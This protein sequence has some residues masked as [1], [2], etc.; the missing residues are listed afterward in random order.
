MTGLPTTSK[1][2]D[3]PRDQA[4]GEDDIVEMLESVEEGDD[5]VIYSDVTGTEAPTPAGYIDD[6]PGVREIRGEAADIVFWVVRSEFVYITKRDGEILSHG[7]DIIEDS[8]AGSIWVEK[9]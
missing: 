4:P 9:Q 2:G 3:T 5:I 8:D 6:R 7:S 1:W